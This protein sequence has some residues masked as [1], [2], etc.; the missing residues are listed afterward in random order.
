MSSSSL[1][2]HHMAYAIKLAHKGI[3]TTYPNPRVGCVIV[4]DN[5]R[6]GEGYHQRAGQPHA[7]VLA[8]RDTGSNDAKGATAYVT[9]E[10]CSHTGRTPPC[11]DGLIEVGI[12]RVIIAMQDPNP[13][14][15]GKSINTLRDAGIEV[16]V[17]IMEQQALELNKGFVKRMQHG[18]PWVRVKMAMSLDGRTAM[19]S[20]ESQWITASDARHD[21]QKYRA[22]ADAILT[23]QGTLLTDNPSLNVRLS[24][25]DLGVSGEIRQP[26]RVVLDQDLQISEQSKMLTLKGETWIYTCPDAC[27]G[28]EEKKQLL[29]QYN[30]KVIESE[31]NE[32]NF[33]QLEAVLKDLAKREINEVHVEAGQILTGA[34]LE[35]GL[36]DELVIY[37]APT[38]MG[39]DARGL[40]YLPLL[41]AMQ[42]RI[43]LEIK[44]IRAI[45][46]D[47][48]IIATPSKT[49]K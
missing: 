43:H 30:A 48:R 5:Q 31:A 42:D 11:V 33:L 2:Y 16:L 44:D 24:A 36:V 23:G 18:L 37:M 4:K 3:Y 38:L 46:R 40:F 25:N 21:V 20:G 8:L 49:P 10:P 9:L 6:I 39:S 13:L 41:R 32:N 34:L 45:G 1:H 15:S 22:C 12:R 19:A 47:W 27:K 7:E 17:G 29:E 26:V 14:V 35:Q 28:Y